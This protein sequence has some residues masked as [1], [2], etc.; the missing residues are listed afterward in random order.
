MK[1][2]HIQS[3]VC[4]VTKVSSSSL[5]SVDFT[6]PNSNR[7]RSIASLM[8]HQFTRKG[9]F[10]EVCTCL[11]GPRPAALIIP[12]SSGQVLLHLLVQIIPVAALVALLPECRGSPSVNW[13]FFSLVLLFC[14]L[15]RLL[16]L[17]WYRS[18]TPNFL[19]L[20]GNKEKPL[21]TFYKASDNRYWFVSLKKKKVKHLVTFL[22]FGDKNLYS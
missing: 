20:E 13:P 6:S 9:V 16:L 5:L 19:V 10:L 4:Q 22:S 15:V 14:I 1:R 2:V 8:P 3:P 18:Q 17:Q 11:C 21:F 7:P 12:T